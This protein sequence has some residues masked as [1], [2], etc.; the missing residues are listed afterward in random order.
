MDRL[1][2]TIQIHGRIDYAIQ[3]AYLAET[4]PPDV[5]T[6]GVVSIKPTE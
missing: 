4:K 6:P 2:A 3:I 5:G 1:S